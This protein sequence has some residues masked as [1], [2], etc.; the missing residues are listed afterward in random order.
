MRAHGRTYP[1]ILSTNVFCIDN[2]IMPALDII[3]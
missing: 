1:D 2:S 3:Q